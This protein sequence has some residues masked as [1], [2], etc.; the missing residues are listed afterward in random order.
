MRTNRGSTVL[1]NQKPLPI[2]SRTKLP[3]LYNIS[4]SLLLAAPKN[5][6]AKFHL[7][8]THLRFKKRLMS[9][10]ISPFFYEKGRIFFL[11][12]HWWQIKSLKS[13]QY[14]PLS[15][16]SRTK[17]RGKKYKPRLLFRILRYFGSIISTRSISSYEKQ[18]HNSSFFWIS[19]F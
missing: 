13:A 10:K 2:I 1:T 8:L 15:Y 6:Y 5:F 11:F 14:K 4:R 18:A 19:A 3:N 16:I 9:P 12:S 7:Y 17:N